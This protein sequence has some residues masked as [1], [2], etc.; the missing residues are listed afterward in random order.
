MVAKDKC[1][2]LMRYDF[3]EGYILWLAKTIGSE[4]LKFITAYLFEK[5]MSN[6]LEDFAGPVGVVCDLLMVPVKE[7]DTKKTSGPGTQSALELK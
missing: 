1:N 6:F 4:L 2:W 3:A 7:A 5:V